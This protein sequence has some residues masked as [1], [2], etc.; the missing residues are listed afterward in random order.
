MHGGWIGLM[1]ILA[2]GAE[3]GGAPEFML[4][5]VVLVASAALIAYLCQRLGLVSIV[6]FLLPGVLVAP[7]D[8]G[9]VRSGRT[10]EEVAQTGVILLLFTIGMELSIERLVQLRRLVLAGGGLQVGLTTALVTGILAL[11][12]VDVRTG[13]YSGF[14]VALS[15]TA[16]VLTVLGTRGE[17]GAEH[18]RIGLSLLVFQ[19]LAIVAMVMVVPM[20]S[21]QG[22]DTVDLLW[23]VARAGLIILVVMV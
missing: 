23:A 12:G 19:D 16:I 22:G 4:E 15:S 13:I 9:V 3:A 8:L 10:L 17:R 6:G 2:A 21:G 5:L 1:E 11:A 18:G 7:N 20:L 14:L